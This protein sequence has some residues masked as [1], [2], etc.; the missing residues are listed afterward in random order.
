MTSGSGTSGSALEQVPRNGARDSWA[1]T[2]RAAVP[3]I[4]LLVVVA[5]LVGV[6]TVV[7]LLIGVEDDSG[8]AGR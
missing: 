1:P 4:V 6:A 7:A 3:A 5:N 8:D 2:G